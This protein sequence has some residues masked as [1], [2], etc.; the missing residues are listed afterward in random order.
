MFTLDSVAP[1]EAG[2]FVAKGRLKFHGTERAG[3]F[4]VKITIEKKVLTV[5]GEAE[6]DTRDYGLPVYRRLL[7]FSVS[8][9]VHVRFKITGRLVPQ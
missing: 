7:V 9:I 2:N 6:L 8:P 1:D 5:E 3:S 4:P